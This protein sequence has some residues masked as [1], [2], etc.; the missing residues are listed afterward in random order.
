[1]SIG[2]NMGTGSYSSLTATGDNIIVWG[3]DGTAVTNGLVIC[4]WTN[5]GANYGI[6]INQTGGV[7]SLSYNALSDYRIKENIKLLDSSIYNVD[8]LNPIIY[9][10]KDTDQINIGFLAHEVQEQYPFLVSGIK[11]GPETQAINYIG[12]IGVLTKEIQD[13]KKDNEIIKT[14]LSNLSNLINKI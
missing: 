7:S 6:R 13:L 12:L 11:D 2:L 8:N 9:N 10:N 5:A 3:S 1:M 4:P 14:K